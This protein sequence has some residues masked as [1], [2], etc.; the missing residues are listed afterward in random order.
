MCK[1]QRVL[2]VANASM[3]VKLGIVDGLRS[4]LLKRNIDMDLICYP[5]YRTLFD[6]FVIHTTNKWLHNLRLQEK[7]KSKFENHPLSHKNY[8]ESNL[9]K[10]VKTSSPDLVLLIRGHARTLDVLTSIK[11]Q[12]K[13][14]GWWIEAEERC[15]AEVPN[16]IQC[17]DWYF[18]ISRRCVE[19]MKEKG[20]FHTSYQNHVV[21]FDL[22][23]TKRKPSTGSE[24]RYD[25]CFVGNWSEK[26]QKFIEA[27]IKVTK[28]IAV[29]GKKWRIKNL[30]NFP[31]W[32]CVKGN[33][34]FG[35]ALVSLYGK[36]SVVL[37]VTA[38]GGSAHQQRS[39]MNMRILEVPA[40]GA[41]LLTDTSVEMNGFLTPGVHVGTY[42]TLD[43]FQSKLAYYLE[44]SD[45]CK[46]IAQN[47]MQHIRGKNVDY[48]QFVEKI[49]D[50]FKMEAYSSEGVITHPE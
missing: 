45:E 34:I 48:G 43:E 35:D 50:I 38:W 32:R 21:N 2:L 23:H 28:N 16:E 6:R 4:A 5:D 30:T 13:L 10:K 29:Y 27:A 18:F 31:V 36:T 41:F 1:L 44:H 7:N 24:K 40:C 42:E 14:Y 37:N 8:F 33:Y 19:I 39:G 25:V 22:F 9:I 49:I 15:V 3:V 12:T 17:F 47:G 20:I 26:R 11:K 46:Q